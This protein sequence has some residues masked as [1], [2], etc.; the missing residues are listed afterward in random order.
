M[1]TLRARLRSIAWWPIARTSIWLSSSMAV[2]SWMLLGGSATA[3]SQP[4]PDPNPYDW[5][6]TQSTVFNSETV[7]GTSSMFDIRSIGFRLDDPNDSMSRG[8]LFLGNKLVGSDKQWYT[9]GLEISGPMSRGARDYVETWQYCRAGLAIRRE[10]RS[11]IPVTNYSQGK[12]TVIAQGRF[13]YQTACRQQGGVGCSGAAWW[14]CK[15]GL[16]HYNFPESMQNTYPATWTKEIWMPPLL[17]GFTFESATHG[18]FESASGD[19]RWDSSGVFEGFFA[20]V[21]LRDNLRNFFSAASPLDYCSGCGGSTSEGYWWKGDNTQPWVAANSSVVAPYKSYAAPGAR[22]GSHICRGGAA[23]TPCLCEAISDEGV[24]TTPIQLNVDGVKDI[25]GVDPDG[26]WTPVDYQQRRIAS[27]EWPTPY[28]DPVTVR[29]NCHALTFFSSDFDH[30]KWYNLAEPQ[31]S[32]CG[33][34]WTKLQPPPMA[35][36]CPG[37]IAVWFDGSGRSAHSATITGGAWPNLLYR[38]K[39]GPGVRY[40]N[41]TGASLNALYGST[42]RYYRR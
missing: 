20:D 16:Y 21:T 29:Y 19:S 30:P 23:D 13:S 34:D 5:S 7:L 10:R 27:A 15:V 4:P 17:P 41:A 2:L 25:L 8:R 18:I 12:I 26:W 1:C 28:D 14:E 22:S 36:P 39:N 11:Q 42:V 33:G 24:T 3:Q 40:V 35:F 32:T 31:T 37:D 6:A 38:T 9:T